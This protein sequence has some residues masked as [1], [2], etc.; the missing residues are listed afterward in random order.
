MTDASSYRRG[1]IWLVE[2]GSA[3]EDPE[4][5]FQRPALVVSDDR[6]HHPNL[7]MV[8]VVP[9]TKTIRSLPLHLVAQPTDQNGLSVRTAF[10]AEQIRAVSTSRLL[11]HIGMLEAELRFELDDVLR[12]VLKL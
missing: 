8:I 6:L 11:T 12:R 7:N 3:P 2:F 1:D 10:Q 5:A 4:Q 9:G